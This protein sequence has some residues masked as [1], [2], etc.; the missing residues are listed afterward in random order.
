MSVRRATI[1]DAQPMARINANVRQMRLDERPDWF[2]SVDEN[3][4]MEMYSID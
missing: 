1:D 3:A 4:I 2:K